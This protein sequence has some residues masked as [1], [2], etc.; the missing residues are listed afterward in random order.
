[1]AALKNH[2]VLPPS[3]DDHEHLRA[4]Q[5]ML[6][7]YD[8]VSVS[9]SGGSMLL[10]ESVRLV[11]A[12]AVTALARG[13]AVAVEPQR[14]TLTTQEAAHRLGISRPT[15]VRLLE[16][17]KIPYTQPGR[18][19][20]VELADVLAFQDRERERRRHI[21]REIAREETPD[22]GEATEGFIETR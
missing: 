11:L 8:D 14:T 6:D 18:H 4:L 22:P 15:L 20:R 2:P 16:Q 1:M 5:E 13:Q 21:L 12:D 19:R 10:T 7:G 9:T 17:G 3:A